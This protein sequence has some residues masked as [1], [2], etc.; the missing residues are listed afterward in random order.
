MLSFTLSLIIA[1]IYFLQQA[2]FL[3][4]YIQN[5]SDLSINQDKAI[6]VEARRKKRKEDKGPFLKEC[7]AGFSGLPSDLSGLGTGI[8]LYWLTPPMTGFSK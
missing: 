6:K 2:L 1:L 4:L 7:Q 3:A 8:D 5:S